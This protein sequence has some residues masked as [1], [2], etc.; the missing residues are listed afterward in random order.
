MKK[1]L[2]IGSEGQLG[3]EI[4]ELYHQFRE[5]KFT[6][7]TIESLDVT[8]QVALKNKIT[9]DSFDYIIN[10]TAYTAVDK[11]ET[12]KDLAD[13]INNQAIKTIG[14]S[15]SEINAKVIHVSTD[16]VFDGSNFKPYSEEDQTSPNSV[17]G[18][19]KLD[20]ELALLKENSESIVLRTSWLY[21]SFGNN[22]VKTMMKLGNERDELNVIF[23]QVGTPT[24]AR[25]LAKVILYII[26]KDINLAIPFQSG[27][28][29]YSNEGVCSWFDF[30]KTIH[31][32]ANINCNVK[33]IESKD[34]PTAAPR[35]HYS[36]LNKTK[37]KT[38]YNVDIPYW[39]DSLKECIA[40]INQ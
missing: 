23:D 16:Y 32:I 1:I 28:Y 38:I 13:I 25:D 17:Y 20:G 30:T 24:Y 4:K 40:L 6:F 3:N 18:K 39:K 34:Y 19:T 2:V 37:I 29:H 35:P 27:I 7:T 14:K 8:N 9:S 22:F 15:S 10:C 12:D 26:E 31:E 11:A 33:P 36:V 21:S 5:A